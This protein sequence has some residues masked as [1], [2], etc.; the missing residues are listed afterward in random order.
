MGSS[1]YTVKQPACS[2]RSSLLFPPL[3]P[4]PSLPRRVMLLSQPILMSW[5]ST[6]T[7]LLC[8]M[9]TLITTSALKRRGTGTI[10]R[11]HTMFLCQMVAYRRLPTQSVEMVAM[12]LMSHMKE[13]LSPLKPSL[14]SQLLH[15]ELPSRSQVNGHHTTSC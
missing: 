11:D 14:M 10:P 12:L 15:M 2:F 3:L 5:P 1:H 8:R 7:T 4:L 9:I 13:L 6:L